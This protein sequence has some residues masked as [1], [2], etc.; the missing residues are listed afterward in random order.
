MS[1][2]HSISR[3]RPLWWVAAFIA[4]NL[5]AGAGSLAL[6][7]GVAS[8]VLHDVS[9]VSA[10]VAIGV[11]IAWYRPRPL[12]PW[13]LVGL[14]ILLLASGDIAYEADAT[15]GTL[16]LFSIGDWLY[17][18]G[19]VAL[20]VAL[21]WFGCRPRHSRWAGRMVLVDA[22]PV[23]LGSF[24]LLWFLVFNEQFDR[25]GLSVNSRILVGAFPTFDLLLLALG[26]RLLLTGAAR[27]PSF[28]L[29]LA[30]TFFGFLGDLIW[31]GFLETTSYQSIWVNASYYLSYALIGAAALHPSMRL[32]TSIE[33]D[34]A[35]VMPVRRLILLGGALA[36]VPV[37]ALSQPA[38]FDLDDRILFGVAAIVIP[39]LVIYRLLDLAL[40]ARRLSKN[41]L[42]SA[43]RLEAVLDASPLPI[44]VVDANGNIERWN[45]AAEATSGWRAEDVVGK[46]WHMH[47]AQGEQRAG[48][49]E[50]RALAGERLDHIELALRRND[51]AARRVEVSTAP[52]GS[53]EA[54]DAVIAVFDDVTE[55]RR[56]EDEVRYLADHDPLTGLLNRR[57]FS[58]CLLEE[59]VAA[60]TSGTPF[61][62]AI[63]DLDHFK[64]INDTAGH[65][66]GD[67]MLCD[68]A[69][70][71]AGKLRPD[72]V[73][74]RLS[75]DEFALL[76]R[77]ASIDDAVRVGE[78]ILTAVRDYR[79]PLD[80]EHGTLDITLS[81]GL[82]PIKPGP[83]ADSCAETVLLHADLALYE[84]KAR[85]R[86]RSAVWTP[87]LAEIQQLSVRRG[88]STGIKDALRDERFVIH[89]QPIVD[90]RVGRIAYHEALTRMTDENG[91]L[92]S[93]AEF[94]PHAADLG[95]IDQIDQNAIDRAI[96]LLECDPELRIFVNL[97][98]QSFYNE[99]LLDGLEDV[100]AR[101]PHLAGRLGIE[102]TE[103]APLRDYDRA[104]QR[105]TR[106][107]GLGCLVA[108]DDFGTGFSSF[109][110]LRRLPANFVKVDARFV[111]AVKADPVS[112]A[113]LEGIVNTAHALSMKVIA[114]GIETPDTVRL[115]GTRNI[116]Y[117]QGYLYGRPSPPVVSEPALADLALA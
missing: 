59:I 2:R 10:A 92:V 28:G 44:A 63:A 8:S 99:A 102:I 4:G 48:G 61:V 25:L 94:L 71:I 16:A 49:I 109:E 62:V 88:W 66:V 85:G 58:E 31:R 24:L 41:A 5:A 53:R 54:P 110:H 103:R 43:A 82:S 19:Y 113:I 56:H 107:R 106:L 74:A 7:N 80:S 26:A 111:D 90:L 112:E 72:D 114:E 20:A 98:T 76:L 84:A 17:L 89:L 34:E 52:V 12:A 68:L 55:E 1:L 6:S 14:G 32:L 21:A 78:R 96:E 79:L 100:F 9:G 39:V 38:R 57:R 93:P 33:V 101:R 64:E 13:T 50:R 30:G 60:D 3:I 42:E 40:T 86:N 22:I 69:G 36:T 81:I 45:E 83:N 70:L 23:F 77:G 108:I 11:G 87:T 65:A 73:C 29:L 91:K 104:Q 115:L 117:G 95:V 47:A 37:V 51:G 18:A 35:R 15:G 27:L 75:G 67:R 97:D 116:E 46:R 105:L